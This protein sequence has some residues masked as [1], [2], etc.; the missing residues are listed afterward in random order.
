MKTKLCTQILDQDVLLM[1]IDHFNYSVRDI[2]SYNEL[3][4]EE[5]LFISEETF[6]K[7]KKEV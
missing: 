3:T 2:N 7:I 5:K 1:L 4:D 6:N